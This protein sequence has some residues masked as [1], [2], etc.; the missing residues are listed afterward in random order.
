MS[1]CGVCLEVA[2]GGGVAEGWVREHSQR[3]CVLHLSKQSYFNRATGVP[4]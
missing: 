3:I 4:S 1:M 2:G